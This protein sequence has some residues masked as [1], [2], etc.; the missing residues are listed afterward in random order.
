MRPSLRRI[1]FIQIYCFVAVAPGAEETKAAEPFVVETEEP[2]M[3]TAGVFDV[4]V[5]CALSLPPAMSTATL[6]TKIRQAPP[7]PN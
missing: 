6:E 3:A 2:V 7:R 5:I 4:G 1:Q